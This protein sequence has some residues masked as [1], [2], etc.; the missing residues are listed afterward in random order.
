M[1]RFAPAISTFDGPAYVRVFVVV[2][3]VS[4]FATGTP[5]SQ[6]LISP[7][8]INYFILLALSNTVEIFLHYI[9]KHVL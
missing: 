4:N 9:L 3:V 6:L 5:M 7:I 2:V 8:G 1:Q